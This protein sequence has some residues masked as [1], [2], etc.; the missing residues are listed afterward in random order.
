MQALVDTN[1]LMDYLPGVAAA[2]EE[3][4]RF[5]RPFISWVTWMEVLVGASDRQEMQR[6]EAFLSGFQIVAIGRPVSELA[7]AIR[8]EHRIALP[9]AIILASARHQ[10]AILVTRNTRD[11]NTDDPG[12]RVPYSLL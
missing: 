4:S 1:I 6:L 8:R 3:Q 9:D 2:R 7:V 11:F 10:G 12:V 5:Q